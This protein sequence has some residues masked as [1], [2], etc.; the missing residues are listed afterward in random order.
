MVKSSTTSMDSTGRKMNAAPSPRSMVRCNEVFT[1]SALNG[2]PSW[3][4][5]PSRSLKVHA[6]AS[7][8]DSHFTARPADSRSADPGGLNLVRVSYTFCST[9]CSAEKA[10]DGSRSTKGNALA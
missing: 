1:A 4:V 2:E 6:V 7:S 3:N 8:F 9:M 10:D 5:T